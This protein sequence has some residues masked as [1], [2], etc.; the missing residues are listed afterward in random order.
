[1]SK[2]CSRCKTEKPLEEFYPHKGHRGGRDSAC[3]ACLKTQRELNKDAIAAK[4][5]AWRASHIEEE[6]AQRQRNYSRHREAK[7]AQNKAWREAHREERRQYLKANHAAHAEERR[8]YGKNYYATHRTQ[9]RI[10][11]QSHYEI[12]AEALR[13][14]S[15]AFAKAHPEFARAYAKSRRALKAGAPINDFTHAQW[16]ELQAAYD[17]R[18]VYCGRRAKGHLTQDHIT[19][20]SEGGSHTLSNIVPAC[21]SC[22]SKKHTGPPLTPVQPLLL[23]MAPI[24]IR[25]VTED[26]QTLCNE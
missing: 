11:R 8:A 14:K 15:L 4:R 17:H 9:S 13:A 20:L 16:V 3:K 1:M 18:C 7:L 10:Q 5:K 19:P 21:R 25:R 6:R 26:A 24:Q 23:T 2:R 12:H 22:N